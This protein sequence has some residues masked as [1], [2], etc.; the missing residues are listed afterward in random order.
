MANKEIQPMPGENFD[1]QS[2][3]L[4][5]LLRQVAP[6]L[7]RYPPFIQMVK[8]YVVQDMLRKEEKPRPPLTLSDLARALSDLPVR[9][10]AWQR[11]FFLTAVDGMRI[12]LASEKLR[13][14]NQLDHWLEIKKEAAAQQMED[15]LRLFRATERRKPER[16]AKKKRDRRKS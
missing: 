8:L 15:R 3:A 7:L 10:D 12:S 6:E 4:D 11:D 1:H 14:L 5:Q 2:R 9:L 13:S 16:P